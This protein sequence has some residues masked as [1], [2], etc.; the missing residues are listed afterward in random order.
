MSCDCKKY[1][2]PLTTFGDVI[3]RCEHSLEIEA[4]LEVAST[5]ADGWASVMRCRECG[6]L[7]A[8]EYPFSE[9][10]G[11][12][13]ACLYRISTVDPDRWLAQDSGLTMRLRS[14]DEDRRFFSELGREVGPELCHHVNCPKL[15]IEH[16]V[17]CRLHHFE[18]VKKRPYPYATAR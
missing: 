12:G 5:D 6:A 7:W 15:R 13:P 9:I 10:H 4:T 18:M 17:M 14:E 1:S 8:C 16:S 3:A 11:G 2:S